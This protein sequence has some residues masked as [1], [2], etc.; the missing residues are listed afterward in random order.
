LKKKRRISFQPGKGGNQELLTLRPEKGG[1]E[2]GC[3]EEGERQDTLTAGG[4]ERTTKLGV[5]SE[6]KVFC[7]RGVPPRGRGIKKEGGGGG[8]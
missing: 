1:K 5:Q 7:T 3:M 4:G 8:V 6:V 2:T